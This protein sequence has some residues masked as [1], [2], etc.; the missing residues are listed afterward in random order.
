M[1]LTGS[2][3]STSAG[4]A[5]RSSSTSPL[6]APEL[7]DLDRNYDVIHEELLGILPEKRAIPRYH[8][9][10]QMQFSIPRGR[11]EAGHWRRLP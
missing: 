10:D 6:P 1:L 11:P 7:L 3:T 5:G 2:P 9:L 8:K 4:L